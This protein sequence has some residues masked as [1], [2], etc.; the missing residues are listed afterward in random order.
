MS[1]RQPILQTQDLCIGYRPNTRQVKTVAG[2]LTLN[3]FPGQLI[4]LLG[5][6]GAG[7]STLLRTLAGL[8]PMLG[9]RVEID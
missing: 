7:K 1:A 2:P 4:C 3:I 6:N 8:Q 9:G 5:P